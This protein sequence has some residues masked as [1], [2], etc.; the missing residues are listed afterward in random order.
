MTTDLYLDF[1][2]R[3]GILILYYRGIFRQ[4]F[5]SKNKKGRARR[6]ADCAKAKLQKS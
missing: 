2:G 3:F 6:V 5:S 1:F 4:F